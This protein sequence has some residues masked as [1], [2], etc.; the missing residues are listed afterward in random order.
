L[1]ACCIRT[2]RAGANSDRN[3]ARGYHPTFYHSRFIIPAPLR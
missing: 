3:V 1:M 2:A